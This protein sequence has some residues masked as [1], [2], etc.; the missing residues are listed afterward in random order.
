[1]LFNSIPYLIFFCIVFF[2][3]Y[4]L[5]D[6]KRLRHFMLL[7]ASCYFY[8]CWNKYF[9][10]LLFLITIIDYSVG[11][12]LP[13]IEDLHRKKILLAVSIA[14]NLT[15]LGIF[16]YCNFF[17][18]SAF[19]LSQAAGIPFHYVTLSIF[20][21]VGISF[22]TFQSM[23]YTIDV[24]RKEL[25]PERDFLRFSLF[26]TFFPQLVAGPIVRP[27]TFMPQLDKRPSLT[28]HEFL[29]GLS[30]IWIGLAKKVILAD[31]FSTYSDSYFTKITAVHNVLDMIIA[32]FAFTFQIYFDFSG[33]TDTA[34]G[35]ALLLGYKFPRNFYYPYNASSFSDFW[36]RWHISL[37][38]WFRDYLYIP[39]GGNRTGNRTVN[40]MVTMF[41]SGLWHGAAWHFVF[42]GVYHGVLLFIERAIREKYKTL[43]FLINKYSVF[44]FVCIGWVFFRIEKMTD[45]KYVFRHLANWNIPTV[46]LGQVVALSLV[47][48]L[49]FIER[50]SDR[51]TLRDWL[52]TRYF[53]FQ[54]F[55]HALMFVIIIGFGNLNNPFIY[56]QF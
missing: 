21:P 52:T 34:I 15:I 24:Y 14:A 54:V 20:L 22:H 47:A 55:A 51:F 1:M 12:A 17:I 38:S 26:V 13:A 46:T 23:G 44:L 49:Y 53:Y 11:V 43:Q 31:F 41:L 45:F 36:R 8:A 2:L 19:M 33:Y 9:L 35:C 27:T 3:N 7:V 16:K 5:R 30:L 48:V 28:R 56:F 32:M 29:T 37:S 25:E 6:V 10:L 50:Q 18:D 42:W 39:L 40:M 4:L